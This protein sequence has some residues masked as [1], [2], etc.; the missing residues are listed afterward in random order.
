MKET[1][2]DGE[3]PYLKVERGHDDWHP[4]IKFNVN[5]CTLNGFECDCPRMPRPKQPRDEK[6]ELE[7]K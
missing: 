2:R 6:A 3:C 1:K 5:R 4:S 7:V